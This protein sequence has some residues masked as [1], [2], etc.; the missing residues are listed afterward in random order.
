MKKVSKIV[1]DIVLVV[2]GLIV[3]VKMKVYIINGSDYIYTKIVYRDWKEIAIHDLGTIK[4]PKEW[5]SYEENNLIYIIDENKSPVMIQTNSVCGYEDD[6]GIQ[7]SNRFY[8]DVMAMKTIE[9]TLFSNSAIFGTILVSHDSVES[10][11]LF[12]DLYGGDTEYISFIIWDE[13]YDKD[14]AKKVAKSYISY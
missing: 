7:E 11:K 8:K 9:S 5:T 2:V 12:I 6:S 1:L 13:N 10:E 3:S 14:F 4:I